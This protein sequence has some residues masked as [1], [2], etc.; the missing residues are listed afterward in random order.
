MLSKEALSSIASVFKEHSVTTGTLKNKDYIWDV[1]SDFCL[2][3]S[4][5]PFPASGDLLVKYAVFLIIQ[6]DCSVATV[7]N[8]LSVIRRHHKLYLDVEIP[9][10]SQY[11][12][13][14]A[15]LKGGS[16][17]LGRSVVQK[18]PV[19]PNLLSALTLT[20]PPES[21]Y[22][23]AYN[24][25]YFGLPRVGNVLP[26]KVKEFNSV[27]HLTWDKIEINSEG[28]IL[29]LKVTK[30]IQNFE[31]ELRIPIAHSQEKPEFCVK[32]GLECL[33]A[34]PRYPKHRKDPVLNV[35]R[36]GEW[37]P[38]TKKDFGD[39]LARH[40]RALGVQG[41]KVTP[42]SFRKGGLSHMLLKTGNMELLRLQ[43]DWMSE[44]YKRYIVIPAEMRFE[45]TKTA[46]MRMH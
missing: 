28:V 8:H 3:Y 42:S 25:F 20:L 26:Y 33:S 4:E 7:R 19:T 44:S 13:L 38:M 15:V 10:P 1:Y 41:K 37:Q 6:R 17:Y 36:S 34:L 40:L 2:Q 24:I 22:K 39:F 27:K 32:T 23:T 5:N 29:N 46:L 21:P 35:F 45:V 31:R 43:G 16:K 9:S 11:L 14:S 12:P 30:T 18:Y